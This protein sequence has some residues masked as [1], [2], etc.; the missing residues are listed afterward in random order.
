MSC[1]PIWECR[2]TNV[3]IASLPTNYMLLY[4][5]LFWYFFLFTLFWIYVKVLLRYRGYPLAFIW[6]FRDFDS[7]RDLI[8]RESHPSRRQR[9]RLLLYALY[10]LCVLWIGIIGVFIL[11]T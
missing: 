3:E 11:F 1:S 8:R 9:Y 2:I 4:K 6:N 7:L 5:L 10:L